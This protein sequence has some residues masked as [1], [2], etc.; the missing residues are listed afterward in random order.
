MQLN[1]PSGFCSSDE[2]NDLTDS[3]ISQALHHIH[4]GSHEQGPTWSFFFF[5]LKKKKKK[6]KKEL[7]KNYWK[8]ITQS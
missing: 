2:I 4:Q 5:F 3:N 8:P 7:P 6:K 1:N